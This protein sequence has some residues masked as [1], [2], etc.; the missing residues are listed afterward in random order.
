LGSNQISGDALPSLTKS[1]DTAMP[2]TAIRNLFYDPAKRELWVTFV[3]GRRYLYAEVPL[4]IF[5]AFN[6]AESRGAFFNREIRDRY[7]YR[8]VTRERWKSR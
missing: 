6:T 1:G 5:D 7:A 4:E 8:E 3:S 2:S